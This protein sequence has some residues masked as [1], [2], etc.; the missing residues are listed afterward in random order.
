[1]FAIELMLPELSARAPSC[2]SRWRPAWRPISAASS[3]ACSRPSTFP[4]RCLPPISRRR[5]RAGAVRAAR[6]A[7]RARR[8]RLHPRPG[9]CEDVFEKVKNPYLRHIIGMLIVGVL[10]Y[11][12]MRYG[13][14]YYV[15]GVGYA[16][17]QAILAGAP[18]RPWL[19]AAAVRRQAG[20]HHRSASAPAHR[21]ASSRRPCSWARRSAARSARCVTLLGPVPSVNRRHLRDGRH[22]RD[23]RRRHRR[24]DDRRDHDL[25]DDA[26]LRHHHADHHRGR[27]RDRHPPPA[28]AREHLHHQ[29][30][31]AAATSSPRRCTPTCSWCAMPR[32]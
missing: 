1:M 11:L 25:R 12:L 10:I 8:H 21:A 31:R 6:R 9:L 14:H 5:W 15:E 3:S 17:I 30:G 18:R 29:A 23:G 20:R 28:L 26:R 4:P 16:T 22:G 2:R 27:R 13:G 24:G 19:P 7:D 32:R